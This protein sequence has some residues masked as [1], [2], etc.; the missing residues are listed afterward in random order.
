MVLSP[1]CGDFNEDL[2]NLHING[3]RA[4]LRF[5]IAPDDVTRFWSRSD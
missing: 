2:R 1:Q 4:A 3:L 5:Q